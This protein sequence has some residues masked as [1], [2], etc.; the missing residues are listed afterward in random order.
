MN[1]KLK[2][3]F[4]LFTFAS[5]AAIAQEETPDLLGVWTYTVSGL[6]PHPQCGAQTQTG[7]L[8]IYRKITARAYRGNARS[9]ESTEKCQ[10]INVTESSATIRIKDGNRVTIDYDEDGW[11]MDILKFEDGTMTGE[12]GG[13]V[14]THWARVNDQDLDEGPTPQQ[15]AALDVFLEGV[16][17]EL[18]ASLGEQYYEKLRKALWSSGLSEEESVQVATKTVE[19]MTTCMLDMMR[20]SVIEQ[21]IPIERILKEQNVNVVFNPQS[22]DVRTNTCIQDAAWNAGVPIR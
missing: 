7:E 1:L 13:G 8:D 9:E 21:E 20:K 19:R 5:C 22:V 6:E 17:A 16:E 4:L 14:R 18:N 15:L 2:L 12:V 3:I 10:G 11:E